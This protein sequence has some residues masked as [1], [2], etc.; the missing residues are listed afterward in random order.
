MEFSSPKENGMVSRGAVFAFV[1]AGS[2][3]C[4]AFGA[5]APS[6][7]LPDAAP[8]AVGMDAERLARIDQV[9]EHGIKA[10]QVP[11]AVVLVVRH[12]KI[13]FRKA[14][15]LRSK[16][17]AETPMTADTVFDLASLT[18]PIASATSVMVLLERG[19]LRLG[20]RV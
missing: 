13:A 4:V 3:A 12:G 17:P 20:D 15:G 18:K 5:D 9:V 6:A 10:G 19:K 8:A 7:R 2:L 11:G 14:Y 1:T 16:Q